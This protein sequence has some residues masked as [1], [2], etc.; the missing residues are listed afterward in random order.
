MDLSK[1]EKGMKIKN[2]KALCELIGEEVKT[3]NSKKAQMKELKRFIELEK[4]GH[5]FYIKDVYKDVDKKVD[6]RIKQNDNF[7]PD[8][9][10]WN[11]NGV[12]CIKLDNKI[13]IGSTIK[14]F[15]I[16]FN[17]HRTGSGNIVKTKKMLEKGATFDILWTAK[18]EDE[19]TIRKIEQ[20]YI[21]RYRESGW[22]VVN[23]NETY[24]RT[25]KKPKKKKYKRI[26]VEESN[27]KKALELLRD[28]GLI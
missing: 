23:S 7:L 27:F 17:Q 26:K 11:D 25:V 3:S 20:E 5:T 2:Y 12:Y 15:R 9:S 4:N 13:Y 6:K 16:R 24:S 10:K 22:E 1:I 14:G 18:D 28:N 8:E 21:D 19:P